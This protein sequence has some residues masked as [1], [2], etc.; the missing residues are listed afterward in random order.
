[1]SDYTPTTE[2]VRAAWTHGYHGD[3]FSDAEGTDAEFD[4][5]M[6]SVLPEEM[7][8]VWEYGVTTKWGI[9]E[10][11][12]CAGA[13][14]YAADVRAEIEQGRASGDL[15]YHG[16]VMKRTKASAGPWLPVENGEA[17]G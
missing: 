14:R 13:E 16:L 2:E 8:M 11:P 9:H 7:L 17:D 10:H 5:W 4:R 6:A 12:H 1:M 15:A 3:N